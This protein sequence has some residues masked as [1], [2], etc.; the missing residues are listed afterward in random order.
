MAPV[1]RAQKTPATEPPA[2]LSGV[3]LRLAEAPSE[4]RDDPRTRIYVIDHVN[5]GRTITRRLLV[6]NDTDEPTRL[7]LYVGSARVESGG[8]VVEEGRGSGRLPNWARIE[9]AEVDLPARGSADARLVIQVPK[10]APDGE[11]YGAALVERPPRL[12]PG[13]QIAVALRAG[14]RIYLSVGDG[15]EP[16]SDFEISSLAAGRDDAG[17]PV[18]SAKVRNTGE[19]ALDMSGELRLTDGPGGASTGPF[20][21]RLGT[22]LGAGDSADVVTTL[23]LGLPDGPWRAELTLRSGTT[24]HAVAATLTFPSQDAEGVTQPSVRVTS[25]DEPGRR[26]VVPIAVAAL[27]LV[28]AAVIRQLLRRRRPAEA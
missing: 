26:V 12:D 3:G 19:R 23:D 28:A 5:P 27:S 18:V 17:K 9:P 13:A 24:E 11:V 20:P 8:F 10:D 14:V 7:R 16:R 1:S 4:R 2:R 15:S 21:A 6:S 25:L 22:T